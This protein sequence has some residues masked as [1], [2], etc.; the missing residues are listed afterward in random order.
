MV[1]AMD[2]TTVRPKLAIGCIVFGMLYTILMSVGLMLGKGPGPDVGVLAA[3]IAQ[4]IAWV[5]SRGYEKTK[6]SAQ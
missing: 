6:A 3:F 5:I 1:K 2:K 4:P